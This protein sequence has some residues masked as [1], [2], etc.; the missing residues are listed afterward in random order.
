MSF[1]E[2]QARL[3]ASVFQRLGDDATWQGTSGTVRVRWREGDEE[4]RLDRGTIVTMGRLIKVRKS[5]VSAPLAGQAVQILDTN[6]DPIAEA[7][8]VITGEPMLDRKGVWTCQA[9]E[10]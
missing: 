2:A 4:L 8:F 9:L 6:G 10:A 3:Q 5:E 1:A 7:S